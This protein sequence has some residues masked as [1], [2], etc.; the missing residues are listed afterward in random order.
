MDEAL[1]EEGF[2]QEGSHAVFVRWQRQTIEELGELL[3][4]AEETFGKRVEMVCDRLDESSRRFREDEFRRAEILMAGGQKA[5]AIGKQAAEMAIS[6]AHR[7]KHEFDRSVAR[8]AEELSTRLLASSQKWLVLKQT[9]RNRRNAW[10]LALCVTVVAVAVL[11]VGYEIRGYQDEPV[12]AAY[13]ETQERMAACQREPV[14]VKDV[15]SGAARP[16]CWLDQVL[17]ARGWGSSWWVISC[18]HMGSA[19]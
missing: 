2:Q 15:R 14:Q 17:E 5:I 3:L 4:D 10:L 9:S 18:S 13:Y 16:A 6:A 8:L 19:G 11:V 1:K 12:V 7:A